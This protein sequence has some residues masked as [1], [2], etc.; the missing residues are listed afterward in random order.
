MSITQFIT[1]LTNSRLLAEHEVQHI[2]GLFQ[3]QCQ[4]LNIT[5]TLDALCRL[6]I[7]TERLT[8]WQC[9]KLRMGKW[10]GFFLD[11]YMLLE[12]SGKGADFSS[13]K[14]RNVRSGRIVNLMIKPVNQTGGRIEYRVERYEE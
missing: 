3:Q 5:A 1:L 10:K 8:G 4:K 6:L 9:D 11:D 12:Q 14:S 13:Y 2:A 7:A